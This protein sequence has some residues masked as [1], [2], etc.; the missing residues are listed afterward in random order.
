MYQ[1][2]CKLEKCVEW[3]K[4]ETQ[5]IHILLLSNL[6]NSRNLLI[7]LYNSQT[8][9]TLFISYFIL[10]SLGGKVQELF[11]FF[12]GMGEEEGYDIFML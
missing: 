9:L 10:L 1:F 11:H 6:L 3:D 5:E 4:Y 7:H 12:L 2:P 8:Y